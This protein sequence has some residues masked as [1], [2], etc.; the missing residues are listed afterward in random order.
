MGYN[1]SVLL[2]NDAL[3]DI[4]SDKEFGPKLVQA[5]AEVFQWRGKMAPVRARTYENAAYVIETHHSSQTAILAMGGGYG[6]VLGHHYGIKHHTPD[7][8]LAILKDLASQ[9]GYEIRRKPGTNGTQ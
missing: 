8:Q 9:L 1:T 6:T 2:M 3:E 7:V 4:K 5:C